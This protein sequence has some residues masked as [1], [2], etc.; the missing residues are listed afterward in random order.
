MLLQLL[1][2]GVIISRV[3]VVYPAECD[4]QNFDCWGCTVVL[5]F[6]VSQMCIIEGSAQVVAFAGRSLEPEITAASSDSW[7]TV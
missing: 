5:A 2:A 6:A 7:L 1:R 3:Q 4:G